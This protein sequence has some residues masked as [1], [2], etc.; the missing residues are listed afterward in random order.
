MLLLLLFF[1]FATES[2]NSKCFEWSFSIY[3]QFELIMQVFF[4]AT[5][6]FIPQQWT[7]LIFLCFSHR[8]HTY[9]Q[10]STKP[11]LSVLHLI[12]FNFCF[13]LLQNRFQFI[14]KHQQ[15]RDEL[16]QQRLAACDSN[17]IIGIIEKIG[18]LICW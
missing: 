12:F 5:A 1:I 10:N 16:D 9:L 18:K 14:K 11:Q 6:W 4:I 15:F 3:N 17:L 2:L 7:A 8:M 13:F